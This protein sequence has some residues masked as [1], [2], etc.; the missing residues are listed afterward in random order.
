MLTDAEGLPWVALG[1]FAGEPT[2]HGFDSIFIRPKSIDP[3]ATAQR[4]EQIWKD[5]GNYIIAL[6]VVIA[7]Y[8]VS[9]LL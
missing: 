7:L 1:P 9:R 8:V 4:Y 3:A 6:A 5:Y 2:E